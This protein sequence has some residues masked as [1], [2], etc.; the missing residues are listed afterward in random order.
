MDSQM[1]NMSGTLAA[2]ALRAY[3]YSGKIVGL[4]GDPRGCPERDEF[5]AAGLNAS[6]DKDS[7]AVAYVLEMLRAIAADYSAGGVGCA[8]DHTAHRAETERRPLRLP[9]TAAEQHESDA[10][11]AAARQK[12]RGHDWLLSAQS[13]AAAGAETPPAATPASTSSA[14]PARRPSLSEQLRCVEVVPPAQAGE[15][16]FPPGFRCLSVDDDEWLQFSLTQVRRARRGVDTAEAA[17]GRRR[18]RA[19]AC[20]CCSL[21]SFIL[22]RARARSLALRLHARKRRPRPHRRS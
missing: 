11:A 22:C 1:P 3:G 9:P 14:M 8:P 16:S 19:C 7:E 4:T 12:P 20:A 18:A 21:V 10:A 5:D 6:L 2:R 13:A 15:L 17:R